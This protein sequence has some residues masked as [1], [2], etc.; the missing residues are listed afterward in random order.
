[1][2]DIPADQPQLDLRAELARIDRD[3]AETR[4]LQ[5]ETNKF[6]AEQQK[7]MAEAAKLRRDW[8][9]APVLAVMT[10]VGGAIGGLIVR[11][12]H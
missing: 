6:V 4:K 12:L 7:L 10:A 1:M 11:F 5:A 2:S 3:R 8:W 9:L